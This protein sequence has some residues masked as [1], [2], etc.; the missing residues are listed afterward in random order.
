MVHGWKF[1]RCLIV[2]TALLGSWPSHAA[3]QATVNPTRALFNAS[4]DHS[5]TG[6]G[7]TPLVQS[8]EVGLYLVGASQPFQ[9]VSVG[10]PN[11]DGTG[12]SIYKG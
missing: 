6:S 9:T 7:G 3:A 10:K 8:Y 2:L 4:S 1:L 11:P 12:T 5:A